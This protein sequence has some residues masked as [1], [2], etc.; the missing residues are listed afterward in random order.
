MIQ[1]NIITPMLPIRIYVSCILSYLDKGARPGNL[2][3]SKDFSE[4]GD[5]WI[6]KCFPCFILVFKGQALATVYIFLY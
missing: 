5:H 2:P 4:I 6:T 1:F 3:K